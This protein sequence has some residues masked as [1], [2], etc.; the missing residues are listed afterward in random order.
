MESEEELAELLGKSLAVEEG[1][2]AGDRELQ[3]ADRTELDVR[4]HKLGRRPL[5]RTKAEVDGHDPLQWGR[6][7]QDTSSPVRVTR[8]LWL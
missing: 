4:G 1:E 6:C 3:R 7:Q 8:D 2:G 5:L